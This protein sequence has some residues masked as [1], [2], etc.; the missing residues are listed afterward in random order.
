[1]ATRDEQPNHDR[2]R[3]ARHPPGGQAG[4]GVRGHGGPHRRLRRRGHHHVSRVP[5]PGGVPRR[6]DGRPRRARD[7]GT[8][9]GSRSGCGG[10]DDIRAWHHHHCGAGHPAGRV[11]LP[12]E[13]ARRR[14]AA[15]NGP[16]CAGPCRIGGRELPPPRHGA[17]A[18]RDGGD[19][20][21]PGRDP[22]THRPGGPHQRAG[23]HHRRERLRQ[24]AG[25]AGAARGFAPAQPAAGG[26]ELRRDPVGTDRE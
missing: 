4:A 14:P 17:E 6:E 1:M 26:G 19:Q 18:L 25:G 15:G 8:P 24:G 11:R 9:Q 7:P 12:G 23:A 16:Q 22:R 2:G 10:G 13:A 3:R 21:G 20:R 5:A